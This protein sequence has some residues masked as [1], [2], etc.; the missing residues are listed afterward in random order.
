MVALIK[1]MWEECV[2]REIRAKRWPLRPGSDANCC[3]NRV[4]APPA[5]SSLP[6]LP[7]ETFFF[8]FAKSSTTAMMLRVRVKK[9]LLNIIVGTLLIF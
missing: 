9:K 2:E 3:I 8:F 7:L 1:M 5:L 4:P 6:C